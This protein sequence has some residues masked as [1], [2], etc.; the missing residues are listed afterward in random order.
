MLLNMLLVPDVVF[1]QIKFL[2]A[3]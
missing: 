1:F 3:A 2:D